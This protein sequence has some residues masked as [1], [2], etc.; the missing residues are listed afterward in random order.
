MD[1]HDL[2]YIR[3]LAMEKLFQRNNFQRDNNN[4]FYFL[5]IPKTAGT[6]FRYVLY[7]S[8]LQDEIYPNCYELQ[9]KQK[10]KYLGWNQFK[11]NETQLFPAHKK[12]LVGHTGFIPIK[13][14]KYHPPLTLSFLRNP[15]SR[16]M[17]SIIFH[18]KMNRQYTKMTIDEILDKYLDL[19]GSIQAR[20]F[21]YLP[22]LENLK[23]AIKNLEKIEF[24][25]ISE[26]FE[27]SLS[28]CN[29]TFNWNL[30]YDKPRNKGNYTSAVFSDE[31]IN[32]IKQ[33]VKID[34]IVYEH[35]L[36]LFEERCAQAGL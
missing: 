8:F 21:G 6:T 1:Y 22:K 19:E 35:A 14:F 2:K 10:S 26:Q 4:W 12:W 28:L 32:R 24:L 7:D 25:G 9:I 18:Q 30:K 34:Q 31:Q 13:H 15:K 20:S 29:H 23:I 11:V 3:K 36:S 33:G 5:H 16:V 27:R 17:S